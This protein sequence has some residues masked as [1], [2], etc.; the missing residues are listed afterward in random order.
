MRGEYPGFRYQFK[1]FE[2]LSLLNLYHY[3]QELVD[4]ESQLVKSGGVISAKERTKMRH[5]IKEYRKCSLR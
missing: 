3:Q 4:L 2:S 1:R 5:L